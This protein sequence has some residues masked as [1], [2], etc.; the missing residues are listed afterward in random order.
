MAAQTDAKH[1]FKK[2]I[3]IKIAPE[4]IFTNQHLS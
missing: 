3:K 4:D 1:F 2:I